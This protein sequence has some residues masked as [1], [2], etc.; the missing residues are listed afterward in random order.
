MTMEQSIENDFGLKDANEKILK[1][2]TDDVI[3]SNKCNQC[4]YPRQ[5]I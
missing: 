3:K 4:D 5:A 2:N 1:K